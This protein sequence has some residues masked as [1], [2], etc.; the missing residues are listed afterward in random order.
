M[1]NQEITQF[2]DIFEWLKGNGEDEVKSLTEETKQLS[3]S[4][5]NNV[6]EFFRQIIDQKAYSTEDHK[7]IRQFLADWYS[8]HRTMVTQTKKYNDPFGLS[9]E[10]LNELLSSFGFPYPTEIIS[11]SRKASFLLDLINLY[12]K[13]GTPSILVKY[14]SALG[15]GSTIN[16]NSGISNVAEGLL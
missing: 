8:S 9:A 4:E 11:A 14:S 3:L 5:K 2:F 7:R 1:A 12:Q 10:A 16:S 15:P 6:M 13:K